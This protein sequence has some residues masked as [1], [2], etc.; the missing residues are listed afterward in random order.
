MSGLVHDLVPVL[1]TSVL[2]TNRFTRAKGDV[3]GS[4]LHMP[5]I[6]RAVVTQWTETVRLSCPVV[7]R[8]E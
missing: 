5:G 1:E 3:K 8:L 7:W 6:M 2:P 4:G